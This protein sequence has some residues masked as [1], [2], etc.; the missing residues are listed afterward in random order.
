MWTQTVLFYYGQTV[1]FGKVYFVGYFVL[2]KHESFQSVPRENN[3]I[4]KES[5]FP[6]VYQQFTD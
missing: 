6:N 5:S 4:Y 1:Y 2:D 3:T